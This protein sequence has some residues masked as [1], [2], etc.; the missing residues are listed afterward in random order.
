METG[1]GFWLKEKTRPFIDYI[2]QEDFDNAFDPITNI[3][4]E[5][6]DLE[7]DIHAIYRKC[8]K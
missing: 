3:L 6:K 5:L 7:V 4:M 8:L 1:N 2:N